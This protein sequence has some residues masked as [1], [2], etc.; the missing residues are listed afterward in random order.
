MAA[1]LDDDGFLVI[2][3]HVRQ[4]LGQDA[5]VIERTDIWRVGHEAGLVVK[6][7]GG[8]YLIGGHG[9]KWRLSFYPLPLCSRVRDCWRWKLFPGSGYSVDIACVNRHG[10]SGLIPS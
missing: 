5:G 3:L 1:I 2:P 4:C 9:A 8:F 6:R 10:R 7:W